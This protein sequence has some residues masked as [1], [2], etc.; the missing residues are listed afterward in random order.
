VPLGSA[1]PAGSG[2]SLGKRKLQKVAVLR[3]VEVVVGE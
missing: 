3:R 1:C 2:A